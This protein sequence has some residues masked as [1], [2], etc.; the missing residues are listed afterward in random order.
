MCGNMVTIEDLIKLKDFSKN[1]T[2]VSKKCDCS[3]VVSHITIMEAP[4]LNEWVTGGEFVLTTWY[5]LSKDPELAEDSFRKLAPKIAAIGIKTHRFIEAIP[6][7]ILKIAEQFKLPVFEIK[8]NTLFRNLV[9]IIAIPI[10]NYQLNML[11]EIESFYK[12]LLE[13]SASSDDITKIL[14]LLSSKTNQPCALLDNDLNIIGQSG[15]LLSKNNFNIPRASIT[16]AFM[17]NEKPVSYI[18]IN[19]IAI[20]PCFI[21]KKIVGF[22]S[23]PSIAL[24][25]DKQ[26]LTFQQA[27]SFF[28]VRLWSMYEDVQK[29]KIVFLKQ[30]S[31]E[32][33]ISKEYMLADMHKFG[34]HTNKNMLACV[35]YSKNITNNL[36]LWL[37]LNFQ[38]KLVVIDNDIISIIYNG[39]GLFEKMD[40]LLEKLKN[41]NIKYIVIGSES[42]NDVEVLRN[43]YKLLIKSLKVLQH[44]KLWGI[45]KMDDMLIYSILFEMRSS[46]NYQFIK[47]RILL[48]IVK[49]DS[50]YNGELLKTLYIYSVLDSISKVA[51]YLHI[52]VNTVRYRLEKLK[53]IT[54]KNIYNHKD[55]KILLLAAVISDLEHIT[56]ESWRKCHSIVN[57]GD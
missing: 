41:N 9:N 26:I 43:Y 34:I 2:L 33:V 39:Y 27:T 28:S 52:H 1:A 42:T 11:V 10:Q 30:F 44:I 24:K 36:Y 17:N 18:V 6:D 35:I 55:K 56:N 5:S 4:D 57:N 50:E 47:N 23:V 19:D 16:D 45:W 14:T 7:N 21:R 32:D 15:H 54:G 48:P 51:E 46:F 37:N 12:E 25:S 20:F 8:R 13:A 49:F 3:R 38:S 53:D 22:I 29:K 40:T 31:S